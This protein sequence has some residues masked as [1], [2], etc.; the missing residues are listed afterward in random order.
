M[1]NN[2]SITKLR[3]YALIVLLNNSIKNINAG[4]TKLAILDLTAFNALIKTYNKNKQISTNQANALINAANAIIAQLKGTKSDEAAPAPDYT[5]EITKQDIVSESK[6]GIIYP[7]PFSESVVINY[8]VG[9]IDPATG[10]VL[11]RIFDLN[12]RLVTTLV[13]MTMQ[14]GYY[15]VSWSGKDNNGEQ[16]SH[17]TY[18]I[19]FKAGVTEEVKEVVLVK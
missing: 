14:S 18:F 16:A 13:N 4:R 12:G 6:L 7:N 1:I 19:H 9:A 5:E 11:I 3:G 8:E 15:T 10:K 17:G 2:G